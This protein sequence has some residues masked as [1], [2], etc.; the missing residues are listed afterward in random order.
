MKQRYDSYK[1]SG[2][3]WIGEIPSH[4]NVV[5]M[6]YLCDMITGDK[7]TVNRVDDG[8]YPFYV[9]SPHI[10]RINSYTFDGE[11]V[12]MAGDG[13]GAGK[14]LHYANGKF[15]FH[16]RVYNFHNFRQIKGILLYQYLKSLFKYKIEEGGAKN[17]VDSVRQPWLKDFP[18][19]VPPLAEQEAIAAWL[20]E[21][22]GEIDAAIAKVDREIELIDELKQS[23]I[24]RVVTRGLNPI[25]PLRASGIDWIGEIPEH[26][27]VSRLKNKSIITLGKMLMSEPPK[28]QEHKYTCEKYL[29]S[30]NIGWLQLNLDEVEE[31]W[32][33]DSEKK[34]YELQEGDLVVNEGGDIGKVAIWHNHK[35][36]FFIQNSVHK[37]TPIDTDSR[38][39]AYWIYFMSKKEYFWSI[40]SQ[41]S[42][43]HLTKE[44]LSNAPL[45]DIPV[46]EQHEIADYLDKRCAEI[47]GLK[48]KLKKKRDTLVELRQSLISEVV[49][50][51]RK[52]V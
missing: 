11:A 50:G 2:V 29:K 26:W 13:V 22:C 47:D 8:I 6:R 42:I 10:E 30:R 33:N 15:D 12:L 52:V 21:K 45:L 32:F 1:P 34:I 38:Y 25:V 18:V 35:N 37:V 36:A 19:C 31:M 20:D 49:T 41:V 16:Q 40:V 48:A 17:T 27:K 5:R 28:G 24:S 39:C 7:D 43:A 46:N 14:V 23:E 44:K 4:W 3:E 9:R 51:K